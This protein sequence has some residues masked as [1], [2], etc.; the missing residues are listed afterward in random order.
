MVII[1]RRIP[2]R[3]C[4]GHAGTGNRPAGHRQL[5]RIGTRPA[6]D[7]TVVEGRVHAVE[8]KV[9]AERLD[10]LDGRLPAEVMADAGHGRGK[11]LG[12]PDRANANRHVP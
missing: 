6:D 2:R 9:A 10:L 4:V 3:R 1:R 5:E 7:A 12:V 8:W 11:L